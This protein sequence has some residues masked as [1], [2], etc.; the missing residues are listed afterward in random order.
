MQYAACC[1]TFAIGVQ[2][3][4]EEALE[5]RRKAKGDAEA[6]KSQSRV[7]LCVRL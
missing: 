6:L 1:L 4:L 3:K 7:R 5:E 2:A